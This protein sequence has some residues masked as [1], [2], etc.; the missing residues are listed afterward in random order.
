MKVSDLMDDLEKGDRTMEHLSVKR[1]QNNQ[2]MTWVSQDIWGLNAGAGLA[3]TAGQLYQQ[4]PAAS[5]FA[6]QQS[7]QRYLGGIKLWK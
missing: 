5:Q 6:S 3:N 1:Q 4:S 7:L 2:S